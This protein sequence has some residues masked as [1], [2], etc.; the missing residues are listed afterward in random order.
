MRGKQCGSPGIC[1]APPSPCRRSRSP[2][3]KHQRNNT[4]IVMWEA[5]YRALRLL[6]PAYTEASPPFMLALRSDMEENVDHPPALVSLL[7]PPRSISTTP[8]LLAPH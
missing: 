3:R 6:A 4:D 2:R 7:D 5:G 8:R 1:K